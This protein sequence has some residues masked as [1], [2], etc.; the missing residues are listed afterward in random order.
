[1]FTL[2]DI[3]LRRMVRRGSLTLIDAGGSTYRYGDGAPP[4]ISVRLADRRLE[5][6][7]VRD[8]QLALGEAYMYGRLAMVE[9]GIYDFLELMLANLG[10]GPLPGWTKSFNAARYLLR[11]WSAF[12]GKNQ[13]SVVFLCP[14][15]IET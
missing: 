1:M 14:G 9:G 11:R 15:R 4:A 13:R 7:L 3:L 12:L 6:Q 8:P 10:S 2:L 5:R